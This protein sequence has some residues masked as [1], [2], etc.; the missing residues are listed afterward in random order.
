MSRIIRSSTCVGADAVSKVRTLPDCA[1]ST[2]G[3]N[4]SSEAPETSATNPGSSNNKTSTNLLAENHCSLS[5]IA[6]QSRS[7]SSAKPTATAQFRSI[8]R[9]ISQKPSHLHLPALK[10][11]LASSKEWV[12]LLMIRAHIKANSVSAIIPAGEHQAGAL[13]R[14]WSRCVVGPT[15]CEIDR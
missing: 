6:K 2:A 7:I 11:H 14:T 8:D 4:G 15:S 13:Y 12:K 10:P 5:I 1:T 3:S 9:S